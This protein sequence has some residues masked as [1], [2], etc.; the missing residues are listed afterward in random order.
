[1]T[2]YIFH[3][4]ASNG[5]V[6]KLAQRNAV[7]TETGLTIDRQNNTQVHG[8]P[9]RALC[10]FSLERITALQAEGHPIFAGSIGENITVAGL[11]WEKVE[12][13]MTLR[14]GNDVL[15]EITSYTSPCKNIRESFRDYDYGRVSQR[16]HP[17]WSRVYARIL[18]PGS[19]QVG[20]RVS[21]V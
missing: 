9:E 10:L 17:G 7:V 4:N 16:Q 13:G 5:G 11:D 20:D 12:P 1:M 2:G 21:F 19:L 18:E 14:L 15:I 3:I 6:P 8:G